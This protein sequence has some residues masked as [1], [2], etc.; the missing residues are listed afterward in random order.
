MNWW[1]RRTAFACSSRPGDAS[2]QGPLTIATVGQSAARELSVSSV[3][4]VPD[5]QPGAFETM[6]GRAGYGLHDANEQAPHPVPM[7]FTG[8]P[9]GGHAAALDVGE[10]MVATGLALTASSAWHIALVGDDADLRCGLVFPDG[11]ET[12]VDCTTNGGGVILDGTGHAEPVALFVEHTVGSSDVVLLYDIIVTEVQTSEPAHDSCETG[13][14]L[15]SECDDCVESICAVDP[16]CCNNYWDSICVGEVLTVCDQVH[17]DASKGSCSH[18][19]CETGPALVAQ[20]DSP[21]V[22]PSCVAA[23]CTVDSYCCN[24]HWD[25]ICVG[26]VQSVCGLTCG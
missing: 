1:A 10:R 7:T 18:S 4:L 23:I 26:A 11:T 8:S 20:C 24:N 22:S 21:P 15:D 25:G 12:L 16:Y 19:V 17:C 13:V 3:L 5:G 14:A 2:T 6:H 9:A